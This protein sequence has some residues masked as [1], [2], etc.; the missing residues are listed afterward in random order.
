MANALYDAGRDGFLNK[1]VDWGDDDIRLVF[2]DE[3]DD[4]INL[5]TDDFLD[6]RA[7]GSRVATSGALQN[8]TSAAGVAD[9]DD[10]TVSTVTGDPF[11]SID[12][13]LHTGSEATSLLLFNIDTATGL[14]MTPNGG[15]I[16]VQW[17][18]GANKIFKL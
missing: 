1:L 12:A 4:T 18:S 8:T 16:T 3:A 2:V 14:P 7:A 10:I 17:D 6:D 11:E 13:Y 9:A 15:D 5:T